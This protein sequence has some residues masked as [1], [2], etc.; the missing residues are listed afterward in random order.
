MNAPNTP[1]ARAAVAVLK[2]LKLYE[3]ASA[4]CIAA[5]TDIIAREAIAPPKP[6]ITIADIQQ[7]VCARY[8]VPRA[9]LLGVRRT[10]YL[11]RARHIAMWLA[12]ELTPHGLPTIG[13]HFGDRDHT[14]VLHGAR[15]I[16][17]LMCCDA[18]LAAEVTELK[19]AIETAL[20]EAAS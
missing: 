9:A 15:K 7:A 4:G 3:Q 6:R 8:G 11:A 12:R 1:A 18:V 17:S 2:E 20:A 19:H 16:D 5:L 13:R 14:T 10:A